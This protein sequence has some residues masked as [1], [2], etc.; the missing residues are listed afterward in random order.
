MPKVTSVR[1]PK[2]FFQIQISADF[3]LR[4]SNTVRMLNYYILVWSKYYLVKSDSNFS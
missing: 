2:N 3:G 1:L 4:I